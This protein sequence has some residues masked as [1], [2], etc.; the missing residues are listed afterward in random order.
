MLN[1]T[2]TERSF[3]THKTDQINHHLDNRHSLEKGSILEL[4]KLSKFDS[5]ISIRMQNYGCEGN[6]KGE[7]YF[8]SITNYNQPSM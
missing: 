2:I 1:G 5:Y 7:G 4:S 3:F 6:F 8:D